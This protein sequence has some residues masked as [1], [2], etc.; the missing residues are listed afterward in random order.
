[1]LTEKEIE[2]IGTMIDSNEGHCTTCHQTIAF[3]R[4]AV[5]KQI[6]TVLKAMRA[7]IDETGV[8]E[9][10]FDDLD[11]S[12]ELKTQRSKLRLHGLIAKVKDA[13]GN[14]VANTWLITKKGGD[15]LRGAEIQKYVKVYN[16]QVIGHE[17]GFVTINRLDIESEINQE[18]ISEAEAAVFSNVRTAKKPTLVA[19][20]KHRYSSKLEQGKS[21]ELHIEKLQYGKPVHVTV[22]VGPDPYELSL[23]Y[24]DIASFHGD[25]KVIKQL[26]ESVE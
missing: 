15:F 14:N 1:M 13:G 17:G 7:R 8:N 4:Y 24:K 10:S 23:S 26:K 5:N 20:Y 2:S 6:A 25:W 9:I 11:L 19:T 18:L 16:N 21:Y 3:Y 22:L 12:Y